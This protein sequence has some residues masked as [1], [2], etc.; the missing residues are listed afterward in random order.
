[1]SQA[2]VMFDHKSE[3]LIPVSETIFSISQFSSEKV[4]NEKYAGNWVLYPDGRLAEIENISF[5]GAYGKT[6]LQKIFNRLNSTFSVTVIFKD[7]GTP[8]SEV[9]RTAIKYLQN[10]QSSTEPY[11]P[12]QNHLNGEGTVPESFQCM[13]SS[14]VLP[15]AEDCLDVMV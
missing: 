14:F 15:E 4:I 7:C 8:I 9:N 5:N 13:Y 3:K 12:P 11:M 10:D 1:M 6:L 2:L